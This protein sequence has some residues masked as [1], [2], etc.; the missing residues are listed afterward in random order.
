MPIESGLR[1]CGGDDVFTSRE[2]ALAAGLS[3]RNYGFLV[4]EKLAPPALEPAADGRSGKQ[5]LARR[6]DGQTAL[7]GA[8]H[9]AEFELLVSARVKDRTNRELNR[10]AESQ[11]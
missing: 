1:I 9:A 4:D 11:S 8:L 3:A 2:I 6:G 5:T 10:S 7:V